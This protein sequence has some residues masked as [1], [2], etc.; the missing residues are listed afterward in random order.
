MPAITT[1]SATSA[2]VVVAL[3]ARPSPR[4]AFESLLR[5]SSAGKGDEIEQASFIRCVCS[6]SPLITPIGARALFDSHAGSATFPRVVSASSIAAA[7]FRDHQ[8]ISHSTDAPAPSSRPKQAWE[9]SSAPKVAPKAPAAAAVHAGAATVGDDKLMQLG[10]AQLARALGQEA[11][12]R[13]SA[14]LPRA[15]RLTMHQRQADAAEQQLLLLRRLRTMEPRAPRLSEAQII[16]AL[17]PLGRLF[18]KADRVDAAPAFL[19]RAFVHAAWQRAERGAVQPLLD[20]LCPVPLARGTV[21][22]EEE[23]AV[24]D[25]PK[26]VEGHTGEAVLNGPFDRASGTPGTQRRGARLVRPPTQLPRMIK[27]RHCRT[28][29]LVPPRFDGALITRS[30]QMPQASVE[31]TRVLGYNG[32]GKHNRSPNLFSLSDG[33]ILF[34]TAGVAVLED[35]KTGAQSFYRG[36]DNDIVCVAMHPSGDMVATGQCGTAGGASARLSVWEIKS[37]NEVARVGRVLDEKVGDGVATRPFYTGSLC[38]AAFGPD[39]RLLIGVGKDEQ[40]LVGVWDWR[41]GELVAKAPGM[42]ARPL[43]VHQLAAAPTPLSVDAQGRKS[44]FFTLVG[45]ANAPKF[46]TLVPSAAPGP[47]KW[48]LNFTVGKLDLKPGQPPPPSMSCVAYGG[49]SFPSPSGAQ[50]GLTFIGGGY[51]KVFM[52]D[53]PANTVALGAFAAHQGPVSCLV[54]MGG[55]IASG[56]ED[57][58]VHLWAAAAPGARGGVTA[59]GLDRIHTYTF[60]AVDQG[61]NP[62]ARPAS[63]DASNP[64]SILKVKANVK[65]PKP[66]E[67]ASATKPAGALPT[68]G[69]DGVGGIRALA[70]LP[71]GTKRAVA[72]NRHVQIPTLVAGTARCSIWR[73]EP[74]GGAEIAAGHFGVAACVTPHP[75]DSD[76]WASCGGD[77]QLLLWRA[78]DRKPVHR[79]ALAKPALCVA[80]APDGALLAVSF[81]DATLSIVRPS[82]A[83][84]PAG[85]TG[86][87]PI[88][89]IPTG[90]TGP[91]EVLAF[92]PGSGARGGLL[93][94]GSH[95][96]SVR[97]LQLVQEGSKLKLVPRCCCN[98]HTATVTHL[99]WSADGT[100]LM[101][102]CAAHEILVWAVPSGKRVAQ[103]AHS[104]ATVAWVTWTCRLGF[105]CMGIWPEATNTTQINSCHVARDGSLLLTADDAGALKLFNAPCVVEGAPYV[106]ATAHCSGVT[107]ARFLRGDQAA[108]SSGGVDRSIMLWRVASSRAPRGAGV[109]AL[110]DQPRRSC[111]LMNPSKEID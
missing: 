60:R 51:G 5:G 61:R 73:L 13:T 34:C 57:G 107:C 58:F 19:E 45:V 110:P 62:A 72:G 59:N 52:F 108:V 17:R 94:F 79:V 39:G 40:H 24:A 68:S 91:I 12:A 22:A 4:R 27:Y 48:E 64:H 74:Q 102:N 105:P 28:P 63:A 98:G 103:P 10:L 26:L 1:A 23:A 86:A 32:T 71:L 8:Q 56:G 80:Y 82:D 88:P 11:T 33:R 44:L 66:P 95:D 30:A 6:L 47:T 104:L 96:R 93:A 65:P 42:V 46:G 83:V 69:N 3:R 81:A 38:A 31:L 90:G 20:V 50:H 41:K 36:H 99:D 77:Q 49:A 75:T 15:D 70:L 55:A 89:A 18:S 16:E 101:S 85:A 78:P 53:A 109:A 54:V 67:P 87:A 29:L 2:A 14:M 9:V 92:A 7:L 111:M 100:Q 84:K 21:A 106:M 43:G 35:L 37:L 25:T 97:V 76:A